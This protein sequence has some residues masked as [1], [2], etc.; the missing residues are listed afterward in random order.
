MN[1]AAGAG[2]ALTAYA[3]ARVHTWLP[4]IFPEPADLPTLDAT[5][6]IMSFAAQFLMMR[7][8]LESWVLWIV[9]D[10]IA[11]GLYWYKDVPFV[12]LLYLIFL[13]NAVYGFIAWRKAMQQPEVE[14]TEEEA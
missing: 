6:T 5:T 1:H 9:V 13:I 8:R 7:R 2:R 12:A 10:V 3:L 14:A 4:A 11:I